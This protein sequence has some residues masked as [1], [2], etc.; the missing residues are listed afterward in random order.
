MTGRFDLP[1]LLMAVEAER[2]RRGMSW[3]DLAREIG[4]A[5]STVRRYGTALDAEADGVLA[6]VGWLGTAPEDYIAGDAVPGVRLAC[7]EGAHIRVDMELMASVDGT[8]GAPGRTRTTIQRLVDVAQRSR[9]SVASLTR[10]SQ[11]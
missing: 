4:V 11:V 2:D 10:V 7:S 8:G 5:A 3:A 9:R 6:V 1:A